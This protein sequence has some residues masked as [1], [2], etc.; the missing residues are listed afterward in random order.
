MILSENEVCKYSATC[1]Y[2]N[3]TLNFCKGAE[4]NRNK[5]FQCDLVS[6]DGIFT[7]S[8]FRSKHDSTGKMKI[9]METK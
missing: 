5:I 6:S 7:E 4:A 3:D 8:K 1:P 2:N 9:I